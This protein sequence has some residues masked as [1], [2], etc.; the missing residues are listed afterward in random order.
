[1]LFHTCDSSSIKTGATAIFKI[2]VAFVEAE[3]YFAATFESEKTFF[4]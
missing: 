4:V 3:W 1:M 2:D